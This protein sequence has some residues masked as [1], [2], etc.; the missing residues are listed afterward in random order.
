[1]TNRLAVTAFLKWNG[2]RD[3]NVS[4]VGLEQQNVIDFGM[5]DIF[6]NLPITI[7]GDLDPHLILGPTR[8]LNPNG[9]SNGWAVFAEL[10]TDRQTEWLTDHAAWSVGCI[11]VC[12]TTMQPIP[13]MIFM[14]LS[15]WQ[16]IVKVHS[17]RLMNA[18]TAPDGSQPSNHT[19]WLWPFAIYYYY[20][21]AWKLML[22]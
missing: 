11:Y 9:I 20:Y 10:T 7:G 15:S 4:K 5:I 21:S 22:I 3:S 14:V 19:N 1:M 2:P 18:Y 8:V 6:L 17:V 12:S 16:A 13:F